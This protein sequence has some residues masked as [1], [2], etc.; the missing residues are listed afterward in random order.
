VTRTRKVICSVMIV[1]LPLSLMAQ[2]AAPA[3]VTGT[4]PAAAILHTKGGVFVNG[5]EAV[6][7]SSVFPGDF[8]ET[9]P[10][11]VATLDAQGSSILIQPESSLKFEGNSIFLEHGSLS[12]GTSTSFSVRVNCLKVEPVNSD[13]TEYDASDSSG[14]ILVASKKND[15]KIAQSEQLQKTTTK[16][17]NFGSG[18]VREGEQ[19]KRS[20]A[21]ACGAAQRPTAPGSVLSSKWLEIGGGA[22][23]GGLILCLIFC[24]SSPPPTMSNTD[25]SE[26]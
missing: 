11:F 20:D 6:D 24:R 12:V 7:A 25:P 3:Q 5:T 14:M 26:N 15:V 4:G 8:I 17:T 18:I 21:E 2:D 23:A 10:E 22:A 13:R 16:T 19:E 1:L 9:R